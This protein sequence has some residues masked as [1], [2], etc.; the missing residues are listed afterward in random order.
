LN[1]SIWIRQIHRW[2]SVV[3]TV[4][5]IANFVALGLGEQPPAWIVY[6]PLPPLFLQLFTGLYLF[7][8]PYAA[9]RR[10]VGAK[11]DSR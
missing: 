6:S 10:G 4:T 5:V 1:L 3:F 7:V 11:A 9:K 8:L 2:T